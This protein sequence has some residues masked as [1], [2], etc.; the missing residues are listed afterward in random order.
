MK[1]FAL[2][3]L[4]IPFLIS[5]TG[6]TNSGPSRF[7][8]EIPSHSNGEPTLFYKL[9]QQKV[10]QLK[11]D[12][13]QSGYDSLQIRIWYDYS[14]FDIRKLLVIKRTNAKWTA[15]TYLMKVDW[16]SSDL[17]ETVKRKQ[18]KNLSPKSGWD[19]CID[20]LYALQIM[21]LPNM[22]NIPGLEDNWTDCNSY[23]VEVATSVQYRFYSYHLPVKF[24]SNYW[25]AKNMVEILRLVETEFGISSDIN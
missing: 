12:E 16:N 8:K 11:L 23:N 7:I 14:M 17:T 19:N 1:H 5:C 2:I 21:S 9:T 24:Q 22:D 18:L 13:L 25:Q 3:F 20:K 15:T 4:L 10:K 6:Q